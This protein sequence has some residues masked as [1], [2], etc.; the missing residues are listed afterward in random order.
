LYTIRDCLAI[1]ERTGIPIIMDSFHHSLLNGSEGFATLIDPVRKTWKVADGIP[2]V[3]YSSQ[4]P[5]KRVGAH[6]EHIVEDDFRQFLATTQ[7]ADFDIML[8]I[9]DKETS[10]LKALGI[11]KGDPRLVMVD[12]A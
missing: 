12:P 6:A 7:P 4:E 9:K 3:D 1:N 5:G 8:E 11:A 10:A 2:M